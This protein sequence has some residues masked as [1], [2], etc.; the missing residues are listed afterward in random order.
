MTDR[1]CDICA[2]P[3]MRTPR[4][5]EPVKVICVACG[6]QSEE[7]STKSN[8]SSISRES[9]S[10]S[11]AGISTPA[12][13]VSGEFTVP[14]FPIPTEESLHRRAQSDQASAMIGQRLLQGW[15][16]LADE[17]PR[18]TCY[19]VPLV[20]P[21]RSTNGELS[22]KRVCVIC[23]TNNVERSVQGFA[24]VPD[25][26]TSMQKDLTKLSSSPQGLDIINPSSDARITKP[27]HYSQTP[28]GSD[29]STAIS[30]AIESLTMRLNTISSEEPVP[31]VEL[32]T[33]AET[34]SA[35]ADALVKIRQATLIV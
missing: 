27:L 26:A 21:P 2:T 13:D 1:A 30:K 29:S 22:D 32:R 20:R 6:E 28:V 15:A 33:L 8:R 23:G 18:P 19:G 31:Y 14:E 9:D 10:Q 24:V 11:V 4:N 35:L 7:T 12:T 3:L 16:M 17:C 34:L 25:N 5:Q